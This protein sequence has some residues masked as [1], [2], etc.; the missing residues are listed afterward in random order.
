M[1]FLVKFAQIHE[2]F[3][4]AELEALATLEGIDLVIKSY[5][6]DVSAALQSMMNELLMVPSRRSALFSCQR[7]NQHLG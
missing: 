6:S 3:R 2:T 1:D 4:L 7:L 5:D